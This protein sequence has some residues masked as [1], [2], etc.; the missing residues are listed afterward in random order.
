MTK[1]L[2]ITS[3]NDITSDFIVKC[4]KNRSIVFYRL[5]TEELSNSCYL[6][7]DFQN[8]IYK[9]Y[10]KILDAELNLLE[11]TSIY[12]RRPELP[13]MT[14]ADLSIGERLF[15]KNEFYYTLEGL[16][17]IL[18]HSY[19][20]SPLY[21]I[22]EAENKIYQLE[23]AKEI[24]FTIPNS[25]ISN[26]YKDCLDFYNNNNRNC[27]IKPIKSG[28]IPDSKVNKVVFT[29]HLM[30]MPSKEE[31]EISPNYIQSHINKSYDV[32]VTMVGEKAFATL[33]DSQSI[34][35]TRTDWRRGEHILTHK[36]IE[37]P[38]IIVRKCVNL[39]QKLNLKFGAIDFILDENGNYIFLEI[40]PNGQWA[41]I[42]KNTGYEI[43]NEIV[44]LLEYECF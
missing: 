10:D 5:N 8:N 41:W 26:I 6:T 14:D 15:M 23:L 24:G 40:N 13:E 27:I 1:V 37:L 34:D 7:F 22:R 30:Q 35:E 25:I 19:W 39:L 9:L 29:N 44:N 33:I 3:K 2:I 28:L 36:K 12:Y 20:V 4:L 31:T 18:R 21:A 32:R 42:E 11:F 16:Y 38:D 43:S 17:K